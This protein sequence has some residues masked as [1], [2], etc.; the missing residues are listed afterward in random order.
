VFGQI[1]QVH[2]FGQFLLRDV[3]KMHD[4]VLAPIE[5]YGLTAPQGGVFP[6]STQ[7]GNC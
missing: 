1:K 5:F 7:S 4:P 3:V 2:G 6:P